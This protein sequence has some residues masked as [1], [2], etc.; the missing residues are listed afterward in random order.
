MD[1]VCQVAFQNGVPG[2]SK[3]VQRAVFQREPQ[4]QRIIAAGS[5]IIRQ[6]ICRVHQVDP[7]SQMVQ[8]LLR[9]PALHRLLHPPRRTG[10]QRRKGVRRLV[11]RRAFRP[12]QRGQRRQMCL[13]IR[14][15]LRL[16]L[17]GLPVGTPQGQ[18]RRPVF[19]APEKAVVGDTVLYLPPGQDHAHVGGGVHGGIAA[20]TA[21]LPER[22]GNASLLAGAAALRQDHRQKCQVIVKDH[23]PRRAV[24]AAQRVAQAAVGGTER[25]ALLLRQPLI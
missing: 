2:R 4:R 23:P 14:V 20:G 12:F 19:Q 7:A 17:P 22:M 5:Q 3:A 24:P 16:P 9:H 8:K 15:E 13:R 10:Q 21:P 6:I 1:A 18:R 25:L 11:Q